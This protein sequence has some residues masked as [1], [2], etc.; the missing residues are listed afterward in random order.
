MQNKTYEKHEFSVQSKRV[1]L[2]P[3]DAAGRPVIYLNTFEN[4]GERVLAAVREKCAADFTLV[5]IGGLNWNHDMSPWAMPPLFKGDA[6]CT[7]GA[8]EYLRLLTEPSTS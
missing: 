3:S 5:V 1:T 2:Y 7:G 6:P 4:E 8:D